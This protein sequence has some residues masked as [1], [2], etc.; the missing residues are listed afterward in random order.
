M[1][2]KKNNWWILGLDHLGEVDLESFFKKNKS[3]QKLLVILGSEGKGIRRLVKKNCDFL[4]KIKTKDQESSINVSNAA[5]I[6][7]YEVNKNI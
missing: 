2:L 1:N 3:I 6:F 7:L 4:V 5:A